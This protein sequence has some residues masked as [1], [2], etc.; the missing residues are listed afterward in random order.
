MNDLDEKELLTRALRERSGDVD[1]HPIGLDAVR[2]SARRIQRRRR[3]VSGAVA[4]VVLGVAIPVGL[5]VTE[6]GRGTQPAPAN[7]SPTVVETPD[8]RPTPTPGPDGRYRLALTG[9]PRGAAPQQ[10]YV[11]PDEQRLVTPEASYDLPEA[12]SQIARYDGGWVALTSGSPEEGTMQLVRLTDD[13]E[14]LERTPAGPGL[15]VSDDGGRVT[16]ADESGDRTVLVSA[17]VDGGAPERWTT[18]Y[19][20]GD[21]AEPRGYLGE[22]AVVYEL[23]GGDQPGRAVLA[24]PGEE[25]VPVEGFLN[26]DDASSTGLLAGLV[27]YDP[28][29]GKICSAVADP[30]TGERLATTCDH[31]LGRFSPDGRLLVGGTPDADGLG[32]PTVAIL[33]AATLEPVV[34]FAPGKDQAG[35]AL[36]AVWEDDDTVLVVYELEARQAILRLGTDGSVEL[37]SDVLP[38]SEMSYEMWFGSALRR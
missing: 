34:E 3:V 35:A 36:Q 8:A 2:R 29:N 12:Y 18:T 24:R 23:M 11:I 10:P 13:F 21:Y 22:D 26:I 19:T 1:G 20:V 7:P 15:E 14:E 27:R 38:V 16:W 31:Q 32:S 9:V 37:A 4:A 30:A 6:L 17:P 25:V 33:D 5:N 28:G